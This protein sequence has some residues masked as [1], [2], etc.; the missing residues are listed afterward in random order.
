MQIITKIKRLICIYYLDIFKF[1]L[2]NHFY[3]KQKKKGKSFY[4]IQKM[5]NKNPMTNP[6]STN[7]ITYII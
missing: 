5:I 6:L 3:H 1:L 2:N 4:F 7:Q